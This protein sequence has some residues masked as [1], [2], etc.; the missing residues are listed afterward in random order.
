M[1]LVV[2]IASSAEARQA[3]GP[4][5][6]PAARYQFTVEKDVM[7]PMRDGVKLATDLYRPTGAGER[8]PVILMRT[9]YNKATY[10]GAVPQARIF[11]GQ[12]YLAVVQDTR[13]Q[14]ASEGEYRVQAADANDG[15]DTIDWIIKQPWSNGKVGTYGCSYLGEVQ[16]LLSTKHH[17]NHLAMIPQAASG[18]VGPA[19]GYYT[20]FGTYESGALNLASIFGW[21]GFAGHKVRQPVTTVTGQ[22]NLP[23]ID[24]PALLKSL[25]IATMANRA[26]Y[27]PSDFEDFVSHPPADHYWD[28]VGYLRDDDRFDTPAIHVNSWLDVTPEQTL[29][30]FNL[31]RKNALSAR[32]RDH[33]FVIM[34]PTT[35]CLSDYVG[36]HAKVGDFD[37][38]DPR[39]HYF[40]IYL[41]W[42]DHWL[43]GAQ[44]RI[45]E[46]PKVQYYIL[47]E[48]RWR[49]ADRWP[50]PEMRLVPYYLGS[51]GNAATSGGDGTLSTVRPERAGTDTYTYDPADPFPSRGGT[52]CCTY[53]SNS[54]DDQPGIFDH[55]DLESRRD[56]LV[57]TS[58]PLDR[59]VTIAGA[60]KAILYLSSDARDTDVTAKLLDVDP[61]GKAW[62]VVNGI[63][64]VRYRQGMATKV[65]MERGQVYRVVVGLKATGFRFAAGH[66]IRLDVSSSD[67]PLY[68]RNL[69]TGG[70]NFDETTWVT[71]TNTIHHG[72]DRA[73]QLLLPVIPNRAP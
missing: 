19:G 65:L 54:K 10:N 30:T 4:F 50:V 64:R 13:G 20:N 66:R 15:Y 11:A 45:L 36:D 69:N 1:T 44:N 40:Q 5:P 22:N 34:S 47:G 46:M 16:Y 43:N 6:P 48:N 38:G 12:G 3:A 29:Y 32:G 35:H 27:P 33:Q 41:D 21:F 37:A 25:P 28:A 72:P 18:A 23:K 58:T 8:L 57:Y 61:S 56:V 60:V 9:P 71:A 49:T 62:N 59:P 39:L 67:F 17:P 26:G 70:N 42:F 55:S 14:F 68:D 53:A 2:T 51:G 31:M 7:V 73:S 52:L 24:V 63:L